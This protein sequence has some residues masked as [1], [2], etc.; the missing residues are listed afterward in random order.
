MS[1]RSRP[2]SLTRRELL[3]SAAAGAGALMLDPLAARAQA[4]QPD[5]VVFSH[6]TVITHDGQ[7]DD[8]A[9]AVAGGRIAAIGPTDE[10]LKAH[11]RAEVYDGRGKALL[12]GLIN[13][14]SHMGAVIARGFNEDFGF[15]NTY[16]LAVQPGS[17]L[18]REE[19][20]LMVQVAALECI[21]TGTTT[22]VQ[23]GGGIAG[24][25][26]ALADSGLRCVF[27]EGLADVENPAG[28][29]SAERLATSE[30]PRFS[31]KLRDEALQ[32]ATDLFSAWHGARD[33]RISVF[34]SPSLAENASPEL[35]RAVR[36]F[37]EKHDLHYTIHLNQSRWE[38]DY[39]RRH[40]G[41]DPTEFLAKHDF[42]G[43]RLFAAH[44]RYVTPNE[45][46]LLGASRTIVT[47]QAAMAGNRGANP[48][49]PA[50]RDAGCPIAHGTDN[51]TQDMVSTMRFALI[52]E[53]IARGD[54]E[55][56]GLLPQPEDV[57]EDATMGSARAVNQ[58]GQ[59]GSLEVGKKADLLVLDTQRAHLVPA[60]RILS[61]WIHNGGPADIESVM[62]DG[63]FLM[64]DHTVLSMDEAAL[65][66][67]ADAVGKRVWG[68]VLKATPVKVP[69]V[70]RR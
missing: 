39:M 55:V 68:E 30:A 3:T 2:A 56:P 10:V 17:L 57:L 45:I 26:G 15:P 48:P 40:H 63:R 22:V 11:P 67:E 69:R 47:H 1:D 7:V 18:S 65:I 24:H 31:A 60:G 5:A 16:R 58:A 66:R 52:M 49:I 13:C 4:P 33:G 14:H 8:V 70:T 36:A 35:L 54:D 53:R 19:N 20:V 41:L 12:P 61:A 25:A 43:P 62:V 27:A 34:P 29:V 42:L 28:P 6:T 50:L 38:V 9:L 44:C 46:A 21:R 51:N 23:F 37:A 64:R 59:I 32:R